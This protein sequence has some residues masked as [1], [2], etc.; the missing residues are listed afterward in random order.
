MKSFLTLTPDLVKAGEPQ[1][2][3]TTAM[4]RLKTEQY[5]SYNFLSPGGSMGPG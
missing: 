4:N 3:K 5:A 1:L 2:I